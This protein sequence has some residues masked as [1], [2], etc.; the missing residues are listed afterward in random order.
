MTLRCR[1]EWGEV[2]PLQSPSPH[3]RKGFVY[4][5]SHDLKLLQCCHPGQAEELCWAST[6]I[7]ERGELVGR[8]GKGE[9]GGGSWWGWGTEGTKLRLRE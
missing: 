4:G 9:L 5:D 2:T 7:G 8:R 6:E 1:V 3:P